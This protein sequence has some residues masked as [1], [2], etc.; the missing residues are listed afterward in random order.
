MHIIPAECP[1]MTAVPSE[2]MTANS[3][4]LLIASLKLDAIDS[5]F[6]SCEETWDK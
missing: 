1:V 6:P 4:Q 5:A 2:P 3:F